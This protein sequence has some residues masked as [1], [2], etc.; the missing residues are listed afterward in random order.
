MAT[1][2]VAYWIDIADYPEYKQ[3]LALSL[4]QQTC[5]SIIKETKALQT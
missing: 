5:K 2:K 4:N 1:D 3:K